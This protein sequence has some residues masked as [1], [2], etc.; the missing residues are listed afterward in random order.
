MRYVKLFFE[1][2]AEGLGFGLAI[3]AILLAIALITRPA[4]AAGCDDVAFLAGVLMNDRQYNYSQ[5]D[6]LRSELATALGLGGSTEEGLQLMAIFNAAWDA[7]LVAPPAKPEAIAN[8][9]IAIRDRCLNGTL[10]NGD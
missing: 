9:A 5:E 3:L 8:F 2:L 6:A 4:H 7:P 1:G 10:T